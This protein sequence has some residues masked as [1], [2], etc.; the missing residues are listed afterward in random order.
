MTIKKVESLKVKNIL[1]VF[2]TR[3]ELIKLFPI[4]ELMRNDPRISLKICNSG[5]HKEMLV[6]FLNLFNIQC[7]FELNVMQP[8]QNLNQM[9]SKIMS[10]LNEILSQSKYDI[11]VVHGDTT[12]AMCAAL[13]AFN[14]RIQVAHIEAG[15]RT[16]NLLSPW[17]EEGNRRLI[18]KIANFHFTPTER[19]REN[20]IKE[21]ITASSIFVTGNTVI[22]TLFWCRDLIFSNEEL[23]LSLNDKYKS[24]DFDKRIVLI[25][26]HR[27]E[28]AGAGFRAIVEAIKQLILHFPDIEV[29]FPVHLNPSVNDLMRGNLSNVERVHLYEPVGYVD[30]VFL[31]AS[32]F[33]IMT[34]SGGIQE[35]APSFDKPVLI[36]R[37]TSERPEAI[38]AGTAKLV[39]TQSKKIVS[40]FSELY[41]NREVY[42]GM[43]NSNN[44]FGD[45][46]AARRILEVINSGNYGN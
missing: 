36:L 30:F 20:L 2:G 46:A 31:M 41:E 37:D 39:G 10:G 34:D 28:N 44:P 23:R 38:D 1:V 29:V 24:I 33:V 7:D 13:A 5:Q 8:G 15:L 25:T 16:D 17:P 18:G 11:V 9:S 22:D 32:A 45:G 14:M 21:N 4:I 26:A 43:S 3:P 42:M 19:A 6:D 27:R 35:E 12:T 40:A